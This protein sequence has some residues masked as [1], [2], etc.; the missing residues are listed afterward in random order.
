MASGSG[1]PS[2]SEGRKPLIVA[3]I[4]CYNE[5]RFIGTV[6]LKAKKHVDK[7]LVVDDGSSDGSAEVA[8]AAGALVVRHDNNRGVGAALRTAFRQAA[9]LGADVVVRLDAD[10]QH[11][12]HEIPN[13]IAPI[14]RGEADVVVGSRF[15]N[16][17]ERPPLYRRVGQRL[18]TVATN[19][20]SGTHIRDSQSGFR[21]FS[22]KAIA[23]MK[24]T[25]DGFGA[26]SEIQFAISRSGLKVVEVPIAV[27]YTDKAK[28]NP[29]AHGFTVLT[30]VL[31]LISLRQPLIIFGVPGLCLLGGGV[32][33][34][35][36]VLDVYGRTSE[37]GLGNAM[38]TVLLSLT[39]MLALFAAVIL[40]AMKEL[41]RGAFNQLEREAGGHVL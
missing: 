7:V 19:L 15:L 30:R 3:T 23:E 16:G 33:M 35:L 1:A 11:D 28:R 4:P 20:G 29:V 2:G 41:L 37:L 14:L 24:I 22:A 17:K 5:E 8:A 25:E 12:A 34:G 31:V 13:V 38:L 27:I 6:V 18:L 39:G 32:G 9:E 21:A 36:H 26:E 10:G 40:Q